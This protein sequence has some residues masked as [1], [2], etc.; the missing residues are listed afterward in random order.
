MIDLIA[1]TTLPST[2]PLPSW[3]YWTVQDWLLLLGG[4]GA[5]I[6][7]QLIPSL[8]ALITALRANKTA[9][10]AK[11]SADHAANKADIAIENAR[12]NTQQIGVSNMKMTDLAAKIPTTQDQPPGK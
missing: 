11:G 9:S 1:Q 8:T 3:Y 2:P 7:V 12:A 6:A 4:L 10:E 5:L